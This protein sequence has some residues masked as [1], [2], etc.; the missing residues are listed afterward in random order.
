MT[1]LNSI[2][3]TPYG[4]PLRPQPWA[5][6]YAYADQGYR[7]TKRSIEKPP[8]PYLT[9]RYAEGEE[10]VGPPILPIAYAR[11]YR[12]TKRT[13]QPA[14]E[15]V[16][17]A[18]DGIGGY[19]AAKHYLTKHEAEA[20]WYQGGILLTRL[21]ADRPAFY[22][23]YLNK[24][25]AESEEPV[26]APTAYTGQYRLTKR[27]IQPAYEAV[28]PANDGIG[29]YI[30]AKHYLTKREAEAEA[31][32]YPA[33]YWPHIGLGPVSE[34]NLPVSGPVAPVAYAGR[35]PYAY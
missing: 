7:L 31:Y 20:Y 5:D 30:A 25:E 23:D 6:P 8:A 35:W 3:A 17:P 10:P 11:Q 13:I 34:E 14:Y 24:R 28:V 29:G 19:I 26:V 2:E 33:P 18:N 1:D 32:W 27:T 21:T 15:A 22:H 9:K 12:L 4:Y 16:V